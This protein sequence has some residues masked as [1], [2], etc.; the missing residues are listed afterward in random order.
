M[1]IFLT[2]LFFFT[3]TANAQNLTIATASN[4]A[5]TLQE[6]VTLYQQSHPQSKITITQG[7]TTNIYNQIENGAPFD[8]FF[9][10]DILHADQLIKKNLA[11]A[12]GSRIYAEGI[13]V[14]WIPQQKIK[15]NSAEILQRGNF[16]HLAIAK[17]EVAP[18][19]M[20]ARQVLEKLELWDQLKNKLIYAQNIGE[21]MSLTASHSTDAGFVS[22]SQ[23]LAW[24]KKNNLNLENEIW[25]I[26]QKFYQPI[27]QK[28]VIVKNA[29]SAAAKEF[30]DFFAEEKIAGLIRKSGYR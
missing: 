29:H 23:I 4:F 24:Q 5:D 3:N 10:A 16:Q 17:P 28:V 15:N 14:L 11:V 8:I 30:L 27:A 26:P 12:E 2:I 1:K 13:L 22:L 9:S 19:G 6:I 20:A 7:S 25:I 18:Y 21:A